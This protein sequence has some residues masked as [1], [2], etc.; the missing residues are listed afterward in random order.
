VN[1]TTFNGAL[2]GNATT[3]TRIYTSTLDNNSNVVFN[4]PGVYYVGLAGNIANG[5]SIVKYNNANGLAANAVSTN[6]ILT[7]ANYNSYSPSL[8]GSNAS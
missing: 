4:T 7:T 3:A 2:N 6:E 8:T 1:A 5:L